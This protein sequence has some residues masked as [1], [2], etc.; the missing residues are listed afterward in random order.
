MN[1]GPPAGKQSGK[2]WLGR[3]AS[4]Q[5]CSG[6]RQSPIDLVGQQVAAKAPSLRLDYGP[7]NLDAVNTG[8]TI[9]FNVA[10]DSALT[11]DGKRFELQQFHFH[12]PSEHVIAGRQFDMEAHFVH[13]APDGQ[14]AVI[15]V[16]FEIGEPA[17][18]T[19]N[20]LWERL[21]EKPHDI[22]QAARSFEPASLLPEDRCHF[23]YRGSLTTPPYSEEVWWF[24]MRQPGTIS[25][26]QADRF[27]ALVGP[28][29][30]PLQ[31]RC[32]RRLRLAGE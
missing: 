14:L 21:P 27:L 3:G 7:S 12:T 26:A 29:N 13:A 1:G 6:Q 28:N 9:Q 20:L 19:L 2:D 24:V 5:N 25:Q 8:T 30:R 23:R 16:F 32:G 22:V 15:G 4:A 11:V 10:E 18:Q 31:P 17:H